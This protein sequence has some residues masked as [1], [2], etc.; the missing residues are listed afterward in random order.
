MMWS[1]ALLLQWKHLTKDCGEK[2]SYNDLRFY[3]IVQLDVPNNIPMPSM[4]SGDKYL[5][6]EG[7]DGDMI[8]G[9]GMNGRM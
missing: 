4:V 5:V 2:K 1:T 7:I 3:E 9:W 6:I 8:A